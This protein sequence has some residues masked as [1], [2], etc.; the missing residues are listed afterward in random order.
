MVIIAFKCAILKTSF[1]FETVQILSI[2]MKEQK[3]HV[4]MQISFLIQVITAGPLFL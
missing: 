2:L 4:I 1:E 3:A